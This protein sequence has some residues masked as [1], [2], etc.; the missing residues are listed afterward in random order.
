MSTPRADAGVLPALDIGAARAFAGGRPRLVVQSWHDG[1]GRLV[2]T[3]GRDHGSWWMDWPALG[4]Y[5]FGEEGGVTAY[6]A[7]AGLEDRLRDSFLRGVV[8]VVLLSRGFEAFHASAVADADGVVMF[9]ATSGTGKST[10]AFAVAG[11]RLVQWADDTVV[12]HLPGSHPVAIRLPFSARVDDSVLGSLK[13]AG[14]AAPAVET[15]PLRRIY[16]L[17]RDAERD[18]HEPLFSPLPPLARFERLLAHA[19]PFDMGPE[20]RRRAF[21]AA[22]MTVAQT[23]STWECRF[24]PSLEALPALAHAVRTHIG[25]ELA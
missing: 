8:P 15:R 20:A 16:H 13:T 10:L 5:V 24:A 2:A 4:T 7:A 23:V 1:D 18:P 3:G 12:Y 19:H 22:L 25:R 6:P 11:E 17:V 21:I 14:A 9:C